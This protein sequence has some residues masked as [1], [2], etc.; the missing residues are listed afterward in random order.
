MLGAGGDEGGGTSGGGNGGGLGEGGGGKGGAM[1][2][3]AASRSL[4]SRLSEVAIAERTPSVSSAA[5]P[6]GAVA[7][8][9][10]IERGSTIVTE[11]ERA[12]RQASVT[13]TSFP[14][15]MA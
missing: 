2:A 10:D 13:T 4:T 9:C 1:M 15:A 5:P 11:A 3:T 6:T 14:E 12:V 7:L 8:S